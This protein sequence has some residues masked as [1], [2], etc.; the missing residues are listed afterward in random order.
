[1]ILYVLAPSIIVN[2]YKWSRDNPGI[3]RAPAFIIG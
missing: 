1:M 2:Y 3:H